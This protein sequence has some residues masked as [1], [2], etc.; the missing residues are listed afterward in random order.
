MTLMERALA[1]PSS[2]LSTEDALLTSLREKV[3]RI[4][5]PADAAR[6]IVMQPTSSP[7]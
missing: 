3:G 1:K 6:L 2:G 7:Q 5:P 4:I